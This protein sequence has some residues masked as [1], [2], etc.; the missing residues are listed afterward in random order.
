MGITAKDFE[1]KMNH[2]IKIQ[3]NFKA[4][5]KQYDL[6]SSRE[7]LTTLSADRMCWARVARC[8]LDHE[9]V[10]VNGYSREKFVGSAVGAKLCLQRLGVFWVLSQVSVNFSENM[11]ACQD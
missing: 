2:A 9:H 8:R 4:G 11:V 3:I 10:F 1:P 6:L 5:Q 7:C